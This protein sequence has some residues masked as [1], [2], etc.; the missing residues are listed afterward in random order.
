MP[1]VSV[2]ESGVCHQ[3]LDL[4]ILLSIIVAVKKKVTERKCLG[5]WGVLNENGPFVV[6]IWPVIKILPLQP[7]LVDPGKKLPWQ[8][9]IPV[10]CVPST[11]VAVCW[12][13]G[14]CQGGV[15]LL[16]ADVCTGGCLPKGVSGQGRLSAQGEGQS[17]QGVWP[18]GCLP[19]TLWTE[20]QMLV[21]TLPCRN[22]VADG[23]NRLAPPF[24]K[25]CWS[26]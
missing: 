20:W 11:T 16:G 15:C 18:E 9:C 5:Q 14:V 8:E 6:R 13:V 1:H 2:L 19:D 22:Y 4:Q 21:K 10:G 25:S 24:E 12:G 17:G 23:K 26:K 7:D 3:E